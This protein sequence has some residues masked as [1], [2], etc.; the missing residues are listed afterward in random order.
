MP[1]F[2][3][4]NHLFSMQR[5]AKK[6]GGVTRGFIGIR[7]DKSSEDEIF[8]KFREF[9][10]STFNIDIYD[11]GLKNYFDLMRLFDLDFSGSEYE[12]IRSEFVEYCKE[13]GKAYLV[14]NDHKDPWSDWW[15]LNRVS[16]PKDNFMESRAYKRWENKSRFAANFLKYG[17]SFGKRG[18]KKDEKYRKS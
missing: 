7:V 10:L 14:K 9:Y 6:P 12:N 18:K 16:N 4:E 1:Y 11:E 2:E 3:V 17:Y 15:F 13:G 8:I 5:I